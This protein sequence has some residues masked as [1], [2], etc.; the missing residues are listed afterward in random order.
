MY[1]WWWGG[2]AAA[3]GSW[4]SGVVA[5]AVCR[6]AGHGAARWIAA[7][8]GL[9]K[10]EALLPGK[11]DGLWPCR[12][13]CRCCRGRG[14]PRRRG[15]NAVAHVLLA[16]TCGSLPLGFAF[17]AIGDVAQ[18]HPILALALSALVPVLLWWVARRVTK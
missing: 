9:Q 2:L 18:L 1:G 16:L 6:C 13:A 7:T 3:L 8:E 17:A 4:L 5:Y 11:A 10:V 14:L 12:A 15:T